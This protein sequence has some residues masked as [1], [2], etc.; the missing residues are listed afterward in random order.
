MRAPFLSPGRAADHHQVARLHVAVDDPLAVR[1]LEARACL[2]ADRD[3]DLGAE[4]A[5]ALKELRHRAA[6]HVLHDD[7]VAIVVDA[8]VID[9]DDVGVDEPRDGQR[10]AAEAS[11]E[12]V[13]VGEMLGQ[14][15]HRDG[16]LEHAVGRSVDGGHA[17]R[18][19]PVAELVAVGDE[20][21][22]R[23]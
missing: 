6:L 14:D 3:G 10:L 18:A 20:A 7:V 16:P 17:A 19:E 12:L 8:G 5:L 22:A 9:L 4:L 2:H 23:S 15:L 13:V 11:D 21:A 1:V